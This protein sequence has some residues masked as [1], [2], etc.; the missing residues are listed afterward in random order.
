MANAYTDT[1][2]VDKAISFAT[3]AHANTERRGHQS[4]Y[5]LHV[6]EAASIVETMTRDPEILAAAILHDVIEDTDSSIE[7]IREQFGERVAAIVQGETTEVP[8]GQ[9][10][11]ESWHDRKSSGIK[12]I[13]NA[14]REAKI[15]ALGD[16]L[17]NIRAIY[18]DFNKVGEK[19]FEKFHAPDPIKDNRWYYESLAEAFS[20]LSD[21]DAY[22][23]FVF[24]VKAIFG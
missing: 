5:V 2:L 1:S 23:E 7:E 3:K 21:T 4:P 16:K 12:S 8:F 9:T 17:S 20:D 19:V 11:T 10:E 24:L 14:P 18:H 15:V 6:F 22:R 13:A